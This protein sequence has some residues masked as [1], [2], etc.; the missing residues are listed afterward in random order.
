[1]FSNKRYKLQIYDHLYTI[2]VCVIY[3]DMI[4]PDELL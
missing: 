2:A 3:N 1:M 4:S